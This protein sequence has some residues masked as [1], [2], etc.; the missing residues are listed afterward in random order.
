MARRTSRRVSGCVEVEYAGK[1][2]RAQARCSAAASLGRPTS[3]RVN[4]RSATLAPRCKA[5]PIH[6]AP[7]GQA[8]PHRPPK[9]GRPPKTQTPKKGTQKEGRKTIRKTRTQNRNQPSV[10][11]LCPRFPGRFLI[12][13][14]GRF[15]D[16]VAKKRS[17][18]KKKDTRSFPAKA[19]SLL[20]STAWA[21]Y[22]VSAK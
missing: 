14:W 22:P 16:L 3:R 15:S 8:A 20:R 12:P 13:F 18:H 21:H 17:S 5:L 6:S 19:Q 9:R 4:C 11:V 7:C 10:T 2:F 1:S